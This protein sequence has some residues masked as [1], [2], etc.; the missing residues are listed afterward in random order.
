[1]PFLIH[2]ITEKLT[3]TQ[4]C[5]T[6][7][8]WAHVRRDHMEWNR[9]YKMMFCILV[10]FVPMCRGCSS[11]WMHYDFLLDIPCTSNRLLFS[12]YMLR[13]MKA[14]SLIHLMVSLFFFMDKSEIRT[15]Q[16]Q[17]PEYE[18]I[19]SVDHLMVMESSHSTIVVKQWQYCPV[20]WWLK[21]EVRW[22]VFFLASLSGLYLCNVLSFSFILF[23]LKSVTLIQIEYRIMHYVC[24][25]LVFEKVFF[26]RASEC[27]HSWAKCGKERSFVYVLKTFLSELIC[28]QLDSV[29]TG[30][31]FNLIIQ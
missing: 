2:C 10:D 19:Y 25:F 31:D 29:F 27:V 20:R 3:L 21:I 8:K 11:L 15:S 22:Q 23:R 1:M 30:I 12:F 26:L 18:P 14:L 7:L 9:I 28:F 4:K 5:R 17:I 6:Q 24:L 13:R 16:K